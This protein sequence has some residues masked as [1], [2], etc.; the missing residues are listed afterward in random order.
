MALYFMSVQN[1]LLK[2]NKEKSF[3]AASAKV[4]SFAGYARASGQMLGQQFDRCWSA[5]DQS[6]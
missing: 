2:A 6:G 5:D 1:E 3:I 4:Q